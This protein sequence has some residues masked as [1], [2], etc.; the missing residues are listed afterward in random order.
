MNYSIEMGSGTITYV[1]SFI[2][3]DS[4]VQKLIGAYT[5][6]Y[7]YT[8]TKRMVISQAYFHFFSPPD[9]L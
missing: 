4:G 7:M 6:R 1:P 9:I 3:I 2:K 5:Y 8:C